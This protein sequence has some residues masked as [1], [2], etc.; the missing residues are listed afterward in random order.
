ML[1]NC[2]FKWLSSTAVQAA[3]FES[4]LQGITSLNRDNCEYEYIREL[5]EN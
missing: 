2:E 3:D 5:Y 4:R 1:Y